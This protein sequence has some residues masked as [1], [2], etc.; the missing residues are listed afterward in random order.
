MS[1]NTKRTFLVL[2][3]SMED[4]LVIN[5]NLQAPNGQLLHQNLQSYP[6]KKI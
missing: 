3:E 4:K 1:A 2:L 5:R 6:R